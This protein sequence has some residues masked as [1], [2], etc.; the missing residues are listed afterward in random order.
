MLGVELSKLSSLKLLIVGKSESNNERS[1][2]G[3][4]TISTYPPNPIGIHYRVPKGKVAEP[5]V[6]LLPAQN[7]FRG[8]SGSRQLKPRLKASAN[9]RLVVQS[10]RASKCEL[11]KSTYFVFVLVITVTVFKGE[12]GAVTGQQDLRRTNVQR[13]S[14]RTDIRC[15]VSIP[16]IRAMKNEVF[17]LR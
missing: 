14:V 8:R 13:M 3:I 6:I 5:S 15:C 11:A 4:P 17:G 2:N 10:R 1:T 7:R 12:E 9:Y 16:R